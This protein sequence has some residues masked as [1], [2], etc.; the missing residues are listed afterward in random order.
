MFRVN[1]MKQAPISV[2]IPT[3]NR[4]DM[5]RDAIDSVLAQTIQPAQIVVLDDGSKED[6]APSLAQY[7]GRIEYHRQEN[8]GLSA[9]RNSGIGFATEPLVAFIDDD[10]VWHPRK[11]ELQ[12]RAVQRDSDIG[13]L[14]A[15]QFD[16]P[17]A[18]FPELPESVDDC[19]AGVTWE[20]LV[21]RTLIPI[22]SVLVKREL[23]DRVGLFDLT[24]RIS[25]DREL[26]L[27]VAEVAKV[28]MIQLPL[29]GYRDTPGSLCKLLDLREF[30]QRQILRQVAERGALR[31]RWLL[32]CKA[33]SYMHHGCA[34]V[35]AW[36]GD[37]AGAAA[38]ALK[39]LLYYPLPYRREE[40]NTPMARPK[41]LA[42][43]LLRLAHLKAAD[44]GPSAKRAPAAHALQSLRRVA[45]DPLQPAALAAVPPLPV[46]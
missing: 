8:G 26:F 46:S 16:W 15:D 13:L 42:V 41:R 18:T 40:G 14:G 11:L 1:G 43:N 7:G 25:Q 32:R 24:L 20:Q 29:L 39:S 31:G 27:R 44:A 9:A 4:P 19:V 21:V 33:H 22:S 17:V 6:Y 23:L 12:M 28:A 3:Y 10:D 2:V 45:D 36:A 35:H 37:H 38:R 30:E 34:V 5:V